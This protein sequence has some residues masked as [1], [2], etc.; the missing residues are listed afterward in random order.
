MHPQSRETQSQ[1][2]LQVSATEHAVLL[3]YL[4]LVLHNDY[5]HQTREYWRTEYLNRNIRWAENP[6]SPDHLD[7]LILTSTHF[8]S[9]DA[10]HNAGCSNGVNIVIF[11]NFSPN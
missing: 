7:E 5:C 1:T 6:L 8:I 3:L 9:S 11:K 4:A 10:V 2:T